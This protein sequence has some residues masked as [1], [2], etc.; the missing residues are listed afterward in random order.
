M[1][2]ATNG[3][4]PANPFIGRRRQNVRLTCIAGTAFATLALAASSGEPKF[5]EFSIANPP[6]YPHGSTHEFAFGSNGDL[7]ITQQNQARLIHVLLNGKMTAFAL[8]KPGVHGPGPHGIDVDHDGNLWLTFQFINR[9]VKVSAQGKILAEYPIP[10]G[11]VANPGPHGLTVASDGDVW[12]TGKEGGVIGK[13]DPMSKRFSLYRLRNP[14]DLYFRSVRQE[15]LVYRTHQQRDRPHHACGQDYRNHAAGYELA[16]DRH[17]RR[18]G[19]KDL[20][21]DG[22][23]AW[24]WDSRSRRQWTE[25]ISSQPSDGRA[26]RVGLRPL[27]SP[28]AA[29]HDPGHDRP[30]QF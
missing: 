4:P 10:R 18:T 26:G 20:V 14:A 9:I 30:D 19:S 17:P 23:W 28:M 29:I 24:L 22:A 7:W 15:S 12:W 16:T 13:L 2:T 8:G 21:H 25:D 5:A 27:R 11:T 3:K 6:G 1:M